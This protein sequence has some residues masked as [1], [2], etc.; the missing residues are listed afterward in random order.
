MKTTG[1]LR[2]MMTFLNKEKSTN[3]SNNWS[4]IKKI[5]AEDFDSMYLYKYIYMKLSNSIFY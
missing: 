1:N 4:I 2:K 3:Q 5:F